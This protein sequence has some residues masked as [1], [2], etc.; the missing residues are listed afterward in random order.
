ML[1]KS[2]PLKHKEEGHMIMTEEAHAEAHGGEI[3]GADS[4]ESPG[5][6][7]PIFNYEEFSKENNVTPTAFTGEKGIFNLDEANQIW[8]DSE[9]NIVDDADVPEEYIKQNK[10]KLEATIQ[11][12]GTKSQEFDSTDLWKFEHSGG[13]VADNTAIQNAHAFK[14]TDEQM[15]SS[16]ELADKSISKALEQQRAYNTLKKIQPSILGQFADPMKKPTAGNRKALADWNRDQS[17]RK[18][19]E[20]KLENLKI[21]RDKNPLWEYIVR[22]DKKL[23]K[24]EKEDYTE[25]NIKIEAR[26]L[27]LQDMQ[28]K[29]LQKNVETWIDNQDGVGT[30][31]PGSQKAEI[32]KNEEAVKILTEKQVQNVKEVHA[33]K[34]LYEDLNNEMTLLLHGGKN[35]KGEEVKGFNNREDYFKEKLKV[36]K[37][38][39]AELGPIIK[40]GP[41]AWTKA[42]YAKYN[43][44]IEENRGLLNDYKQYDGEKTKFLTKF[45]ELEGIRNAHYQNYINGVTKDQ[46]FG[47]D[48][49]DLLAYQNLMNRNGHA[50]TSVASWLSAS[51]ISITSGL[52]DTAAEIVMLPQ[53]LRNDRMFKDNPLAQI[54]VNKADKFEKWRGGQP[55]LDNE[56]RYIEDT[57]GYKD[58]INKFTQSLHNGVQLPQLWEDCNSIEDYGAWGVNSFANFLPQMA[59]MYVAP[60]A[61][62]KI[63]ATSA[64]GH[65]LAHSRRSNYMGET[66]YSLGQ[67]ITHGLMCG[68]A[69]YYSEKVSLGLIRTAPGIVKK[70][71]KNGF[72]SGVK[73]T[74]KPKSLLRSG[75]R[76]GT[77]GLSEVGA[78]VFG[79][80]AADRLAFGKN[81]SLYKDVPESFAAGLVM[82]RTIAMSALAKATIQ[83]FLGNRYDSKL[84]GFEKEKQDV[85][86]DLSQEGLSESNQNDLIQKYIRVQNKQD[87]LLAKQY[88]NVDMMKTEEVESLIDL[89]VNIN[90]LNQSIENI[91][92]DDSLSDADKDIRIRKVKQERSE[93]ET[94][95]NKIVEEYEKDETRQKRVEE[96][97]K[98]K[99]IVDAKI[100]KF[101]KRKKESGIFGALMGGSSSVAQGESQTFETAEEQQAFF[102]DQISEANAEDK[103]EIQEMQDLLKNPNT[104]RSD[105]IDIQNSLAFLRNQIKARNQYSKTASSEYGFIGQ[106]KDGSFKIYLNKEN[107]TKLGGNVNVA[108][109]EFLHSVLYQTTKGDSKIQQ[110]LGD[111]VIDFIGEKK[112]GFSNKFIEKMEPYQGEANFGEEVITVMSES[113][114]DGSLKYKEGFFTKVGDIIRQN[115]QRLG[116]KDIKFDTGKDVYNFIKDYNASI[117]KNYDSKAI[118]RMMA[119]GAQ[120]KLL[121][122][123]KGGSDIMQSSKEQSQKVQDIYAKKGADAAG[124]IAME[125]GGMAEKIFERNLN[126]APSEDIRN[127]LLRNK[128]I[129]VA[130][131]LYNPGTKTAKARTVLGLVKDFETKKHKYGNVAA[132]INQFLPERAKE[133]FAPYGVEMAITKSQEQEGI[134]EKVAKIAAAETKKLSEDSFKG[135]KIHEKLGK[136]DVRVRKL[137]EDYQ[138]KVKALAKKM[139]IE[140][141]R[142]LKFQNVQGMGHEIIAEIMGI[143]A[144]KLDPSNTKQYHAN[145]RKD[146]KK[147][148][149]E[150]LLSQQFMLKN[151]LSFKIAVPKHHTT[152]L[153]KDKKTGEMVERPHQAIGIP[154]SILN[155]YFI[156]GKRKD[157]LTPWTLDKEMMDNKKFL[158]P[159]GVIDGKSFRNDQRKSQQAILNFATLLDKTMTYQAIKEQKLEEGYTLDD[160]KTMSDGVSEFSF[161]KAVLGLNAKQT[162]IFY[163]KLPE[164]AASVN[165]ALEDYTK[166]EAMK[167][168]LEEVYGEDLP[169]S[170]KTAIAKDFVGLIKKY[171][172]VIANNQTVNEAVWMEYIAESFN[173]E[174]DNIIKMLNLQIDGKSVKYATDIYNNQQNIE[175]GRRKLIQFGNNLVK[176][177]KSLQEV[178]RI[179]AILKPMYA[180]NSKIG[181]GMFVTDV[182]G[183]IQEISYDQLVYPKTHKTKAGQVRTEF[184]SPRNQIFESVEAFEEWGV[185]QIDGMTPEIWKNTDTKLIA[186][187]SQAAMKDR[188]FNG[189]LAEAKEAR[190]VIDDMM[191]FLNKEGNDLDVAMF[192]ISNLSNMDAPL[193]RAANL[194]YIADA[195]LGMKNIGKNAEYEHMIP[196]NYMALKIIDQ[197]KN[198][199][200]IKN[201]DNF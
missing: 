123:R 156:K 95:R 119:T 107:A 121:E 51:G 75:Y 26:A 163:R 147:G 196:A 139:P 64:T 114:L 23:R 87:A 173:Q 28:A 98:Q 165:P 36:V 194:Q 7:T 47:E 73:N 74:L 65:S 8:T 122:G 188:D 166:V 185:M 1:K 131:I 137:V 106:K 129:I 35:K 130:D 2:S 113:I 171:Q 55:I 61:S 34:T 134:K 80:N 17:L 154:G 127:N 69:E 52:E 48:G 32:A 82:E 125:Y 25:E 10:E 57:P 102:N 56:G 132:Y 145:L 84:K 41:L 77:E 150:Q 201:Q 117:E 50:L 85:L 96:F 124:E 160:T 182:N 155:P 199:G 192:M 144:A 164:L 40:E 115:L 59:L 120:G 24:G 11:N 94:E 128:D 183:K 168:A 136:G 68:T 38:Q 14:A 4:E 111:A 112:G 6:K 140:E 29:H 3:P 105:R 66:D 151:P 81:V 33:N 170:V 93:L 16:T 13:G 19:E 101:N 104:S 89:D 21:E 49:Q 86:V 178:A 146:D 141:V 97:E 191:T 167:I 92:E 58:N 53:G 44:I 153:V 190:Q 71:F 198:K 108:A 184:G 200:G 9:G 143:D 175:R 22:A 133:I 18:Q 30:S 148:T 142:N 39:L 90:E 43:S 67:R 189:R 83:P 195:V 169:T 12:K 42:T 157:N 138:K 78:N 91:Q 88:E 54:L 5:F 37:E 149:N 179:M 110:Q 181:K 72:V 46:E 62:L 197:Y 186:Q 20:E 60:S 118:D 109:H 100:A 172:N 180:G 31:M 135:H 15:Q 99:E 45:D 70:R 152:K 161:S 63:L 187:T 176:Q 159:V 177:G 79:Q 174:A 103:A 158:E 193:R 27:Y 162:E 126:N 116:L 76:S